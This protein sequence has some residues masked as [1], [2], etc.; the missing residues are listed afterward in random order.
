MKKPKGNFYPS[1]LET[2]KTNAL[3]FFGRITSKA[4][5]EGIWKQILRCKEKT[6]EIIGNPIRGQITTPQGAPSGKVRIHRTKSCR[7]P[8]AVKIPEAE[9][10]GLDLSLHLSR[11]E[12]PTARGNGNL[13]KV[14][15]SHECF[16]TL[17]GSK[18]LNCYFF[19]VS[20]KG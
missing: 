7:L 11:S 4:T 16:D 13:T 15:A 10:A 18:I 20:Q 12:K 14:T 8:W 17:E 3:S 1:H 19:G 9:A 5:R 2:L 6:I